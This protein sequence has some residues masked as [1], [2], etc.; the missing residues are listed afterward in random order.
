MPQMTEKKEYVKPTIQ[1]VSVEPT[2][3][4]APCNANIIACNTGGFPLVASLTFS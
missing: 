3:A 1:R 4:L 2:E